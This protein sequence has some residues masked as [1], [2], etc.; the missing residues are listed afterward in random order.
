MMQGR[1]IGRR[2]ARLRASHGES[3]REAAVRTGVSH[4]TIYR[5]ESGECE[6]GGKTLKRIAAGYGVPLEWL[7]SGRDPRPN[8]AH[9]LPAQIMETSRVIP[10]ERLRQW[11]A[12]VE[13]AE[14]RGLTPEHMQMAIQLM[15]AQTTDRKQTAR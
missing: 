6:A 1:E 5:V 11:V 15:T 12:V 8:L 14:T 4:T 10:A 9:Q 7:L 3:Y 13:E 2:V